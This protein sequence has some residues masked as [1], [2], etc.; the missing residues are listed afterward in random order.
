MSTS[1]EHNKT[2]KRKILWCVLFGIID[3]LLL[4]WLLLSAKAC[5]GLTSSDNIVAN[6]GSREIPLRDTVRLMTHDGYRVIV[7][8]AASGNVVPY[9][10]IDGEVM[11]AGVRDT[12][13]LTTDGN[14]IAFLP[15]REPTDSVLDLYI[16]KDGFS[17]ERIYHEAV[18]DIF[19]A[20][21]NLI[22]GFEPPTGCSGK[23]QDNMN[24]D[25]GMH[26]VED[27]DMGQASGSFVF[28]YFTDTAPD[29]IIV[30]DGPSTQMGTA[31]VLF[32]YNGAT[33]M[34][35]YSKT[36]TFSSRVISVVVNGGTNWYY[37]VNCPNV[38]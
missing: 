35:K 27:Y 25:K 36:L 10:S 15:F 16:T 21:K 38:Q 29:E 8:D 18:G 24:R 32:H 4:L 12:I 9:T 33:N 13:H 6:M 2:N 1:N 14:G 28:E 30:Y 5:S 22:I 23:Q 31:K 17:G 3:V 37:V 7:R 34:S 11:F 26:N 20:D 19:D